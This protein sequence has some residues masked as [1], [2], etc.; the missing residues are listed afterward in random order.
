MRNSGIN[1][2]EKA[3]EGL[4]GSEKRLHVEIVNTAQ[5]QPM[6]AQLCSC[7]PFL[8][9]AEPRLMDVEHVVLVGPVFEKPVLDRALPGSRAALRGVSM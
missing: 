2:S 1:S 4:V 9:R 5:L 6:K 3:Q 7:K 8:P